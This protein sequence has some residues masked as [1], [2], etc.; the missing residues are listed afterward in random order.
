MTE[1]QKA[2]TESLDEI[3]STLKE[4]TIKFEEAGKYYSEVCEN[5]TK[6]QLNKLNNLFGESAGQV[7][8]FNE[9]MDRCFTRLSMLDAK[10]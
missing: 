7:M 6:E 4:A 10:N 8:L 9:A 5:P 3:I 1:N 2:V